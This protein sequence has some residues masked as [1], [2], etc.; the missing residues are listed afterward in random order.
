MGKIDKFM[1]ALETL[2]D[3]RYRYY[4]GSANSVG[5]SKFV[6][7][8]LKKAGIIKE[9]ETFH[10]ASGNVGVL[11]DTTRF[12]KI[13]WSA[14]NL[15]RGDIMWSNGHHVAVWDGKTGVHEAAPESTHGIC[16]NGKTGVGH[17]PQ[18]TYYNCGTGTKVWSC[19]YRIID[20]E[21]VKETVQ[22]AAKEAVKAA[23]TAVIDKAGIIKALIAYLP[24]IKYGSTGTT[25]KA[26][27]TILKKHGWYTDVIDGY[28]GPNTVKGIKLMQTAL[29][30]TADGLCGQVTWN[31]LLI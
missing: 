18:H 13:P 28:A 4:N 29:G 10:A 25:V 6:E 30:V 20:Q 7:L 31:A 16:A 14:N 27:Q 22:D 9:G 2:G 17:W 24:D 15:Q 5:C 19:L 8:A 1:D 21:A 26:L 3:G 23:S 12:Q 11:A